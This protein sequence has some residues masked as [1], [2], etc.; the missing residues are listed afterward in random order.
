MIKIAICDDSQEDREL[1]CSLLSTIAAQLHYEWE[2]TIFTNGLDLSNNEQHFDLLFLDIVMKGQ[3]GI[4]TLNTLN[5]SDTLIVFMST[6]NDRWR[7]LFHHNVIGF[8]DK[9]LTLEE[10]SFYIKKALDNIHNDKAKLFTFN[11]QGKT[12][13]LRY[14]EIMFFESMGHYVRI[15]TTTETVEYKGK[16]KDIWTI[17]SQETSFCMP[18]RS[19]VVNMNFV[20]I[21]SKSQLHL[22]Q[23]NRDISIGRT[24]KEETISRFMNYINNKNTF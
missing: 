24:N 9:P 5:Q 16:L 19:F 1:L 21:S 4:E 17:F 18:N 13:F 7:E 22:E 11:K 12:Y 8:I 23:L 2:L 20:S 14:K 10:T 6:T 15:Q 3:D